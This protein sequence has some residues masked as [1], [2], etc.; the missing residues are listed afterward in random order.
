MESC[1]VSAFSH[2]DSL[3]SIQDIR[4]AL[5]Q[6][7]AEE[8]K[9][10]DRLEALIQME[11][12]LDKEMKKI[13]TA[14]PTVEALQHSSRNLTGMISS[15]ARLADRVSGRV[16]RLDD[17]KKRVGETKKRVEDLLVLKSCSY[18]VNS[19]LKRDDYEQA[20]MHIHSFLNLDK[21][22]LTISEADAEGDSLASR[23]T[24][25]NTL[26]DAK[27]KLQKTIR[28]KF[29]QAVHSGDAASVER[30][31]KIFPRLGLHEEGIIKFGKYLS[32]QISSSADANFKASMEENA[33]SSSKRSHVQFADLL[34]MLFESIAQAVEARQPLI[35]TY[36]GPG[37]IFTLLKLLQEEADRQSR[38]ILDTFKTGRNYLAKARLAQS[39]MLTRNF[40]GTESVIDPK[41]LDL[42]LSEVI[43]L[44]TRTEVFWRFMQVRLESDVDSL[45]ET[46]QENFLDAL[47]N[48]VIEKSELCRTMQEVMGHY[49]LMEEYFMRISVAKAESLDSIDED[50]AQATSSMVDDVFFI[51][52]K[53]LRRALSSGSADV[54]CA[55]L[56]HT[57]TI[58]DEEYRDILKARLNNSAGFAA[59]ANSL[60]DFNQAYSLVQS[61]FQQGKIQS[62]KDSE[63]DKALFLSALN[64]AEVSSEYAQ[65]LRKTFEEECHRTASTREWRPQSLAKVESCIAD[66]GAVSK[67]FQELIDHGLAQLRANVLK[68]RVKPFVDNFAAISHDISEE[69]FANYEANDP[70]VQALIVCVDGL[71][72]SFRESLTPNNY[73]GLVA[74]LTAEIVTRL[75]K[76]AAKSAFNRLGGLQFDKEL[77]SL[78]AYLSST[79]S[80]TIRDKF[81]KVSQTAS[82]LNLEVPS[83]M[84]E[85][86]GSG[87]GAMGGGGGAWSRWTKHEIKSVMTL[88]VDFRAEDVN[89]V[90]RR[91][92]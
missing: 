77:R 4:D 14:I 46:E 73:D 63:R 83:E 41:E 44:N 55:M 58:L 85:L 19:A 71:L 59:W 86:W 29:D 88:R 28:A 68:P 11:P 87:G 65:T 66:L 60:L 18:D 21:S 92:T 39:A 64:S 72:S 38:K 43:L 76:A 37:K 2:V 23:E 56:N 26:N 12:E 30:F 67:R 45:P 74:Q 40:T 53:C 61:S 70:W 10:E 51:I 6:I 54:T 20:A 16:R 15:T 49:V 33:Q 57:S 78:V 89:N 7:E 90:V 50:L 8:K 48:D 82:I 80:W 3:T 31:L 34:T 84:E 79:T 42:L 22:V 52:K 91:L 13:Q 32:A 5:A 25:Y 1:D 17:A 27:D 9:T 69:D 24:S 47:K 75:E 35:E 62:A 81:A 36:Y